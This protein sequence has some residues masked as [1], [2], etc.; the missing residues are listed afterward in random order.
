MITNTHYIPSSKKS[1]NS[2][3]NP[4]WIPFES[5]GPGSY[6]NPNVII[7]QDYVISIPV[8]PVPR[9]GITI[10]A[11]T[12][13]GEV[14]TSNYEYPMGTIGA[15]LNGVTMFNS[16][17]AP[18]DVIE[19]EVLSFD[20]YNGHPAGETYHYHTIS[21]GPLEV[22]QKKLQ[23]FTFK[24]LQM[25]IAISWHIRNSHLVVITPASKTSKSVKSLNALRNVQGQKL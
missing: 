18:G 9:S 6:Q 2:S 1:Q 25:C 4:N 24:I 19:N 20:L 7:E 12:V 21:Q 15:A 22:L 11:S 16:L 13:D 23:I 5:F 14:N 8:D 10:D 17:A 3:D